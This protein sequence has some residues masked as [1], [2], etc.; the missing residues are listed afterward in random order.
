MK[1]H[2][3]PTT[4]YNDRADHLRPSMLIIHSMGLPVG[5]ALDLL[6]VSAIEASAHYAITPEGDIYSF[7][8]EHHR[9]WHAGKSTWRGLEDINSHSIGIELI[10]PGPDNTEK[11]EM[12]VPG[13]FSLLQMNSLTNLSLDIL[14]RWNISTDSVLAHSDIAP[15]RKRDPGE[16][17]NWADFAAAGVGLWPDGPLPLP[18][19]APTLEG[20]ARYGYDVSDPQA[21]LV[22]FQRH[23][24]P[25]NCTGEDDTRTRQI[26]NWLLQKTGR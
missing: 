18:L 10:A 1:I 2:P 26:L 15:G 6:T 5:T 22:A 14:R 7:V 17:F 20:L 9:A 25:T 16:R 13:P 24:R 19:E 3:L 8:S 23:F 21:A 4:K 11:D 12:D